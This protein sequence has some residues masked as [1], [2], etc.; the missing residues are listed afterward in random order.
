MKAFAVVSDENP[1]IGFVVK[2]KDEKDY[3]RAKRIALHGF[4]RWNNPE[5]YPECAYCGYSEPSKYLLDEVGIPCEIDDYY[6]E[7]E[8][9]D[10]IYPSNYES[11]AIRVKPEYEGIE[12]VGGLFS[13]I[14]EYD[15]KEDQND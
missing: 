5:F 15:E 3:D 10:C 1:G 13:E 12:E 6:E 7:C 14:D 11:M 8:L 9:K 4:E 2:V